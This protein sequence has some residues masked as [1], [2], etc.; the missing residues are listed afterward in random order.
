MTRDAGRALAMAPEHGPWRSFARLLHGIGLCLA[1]RTDEARDELSDAAR[2]AVFDAPLVRALALAV[3]AFLETQSGERDEAAALAGQARRTLER[4]GAADFPLGALVLAVSAVARGER[5]DLDG[6]RE[7]ATHA[8]ADLCALPDPSPWYGVLTRIALARAE[9]RLSDAPAAARLLGETSRLLRQSPGAV[10]LHAWVDEGWAQV[11]DYAAGPVA[12]PT[13]LTRAELRVLR[14]L[15]SHLSFRE[16][17]ARLHVSANTVKT[18]AHAV[19]R[20]LDARSRSEA[21]AHARAMGLVDTEIIH[22]G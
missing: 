21:V 8:A 17:A 16:I 12:C 15:P 6:A 5:G 19:Y 11:D 3:L 10:A 22:S 2:A 4:H 1:G 20:K 7:D 13:A 18:Q 9:L 14:F